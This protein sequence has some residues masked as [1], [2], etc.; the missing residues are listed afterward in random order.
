MRRTTKI[1]KDTNQELNQKCSNLQHSVSGEYNETLPVKILAFARPLHLQKYST[2][3]SETKK[4]GT[5]LSVTPQ[6]CFQIWQNLH[7]QDLNY[8]ESLDAWEVAQF[9]QVKVASKLVFNSMVCADN[10][11]WR[12]TTPWTLESVW[13]KQKCK[14]DHHHHHHS[15]HHHKNA[16]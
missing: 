12:E 3:R 13:K 11:W 10:G 2:W 16:I 7:C 4:R 1:N 6:N 15:H 5:Q 9:R 14:S 8:W